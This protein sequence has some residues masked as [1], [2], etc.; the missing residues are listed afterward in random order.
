MVKTLFRQNSQTIIR[1]TNPNHH[2]DHHPVHYQVLDKWEDS[3][4]PSI[5]QMWIRY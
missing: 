3:D 1:P 2:P 5:H 4:L